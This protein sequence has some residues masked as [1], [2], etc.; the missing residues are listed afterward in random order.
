MPHTANAA[1]DSRATRKR[2]KIWGKSEIFSLTRQF[3][4]LL[5]AKNFSFHFSYP[6]L[7]QD[8]KKNVWRGTNLCVSRLKKFFDELFEIFQHFWWNFSNIFFLFS[9]VR[10]GRVPKREKAR[11]EA[12]MQQQTRNRAL[13]THVWTDGIED[14][15]HIIDTVVGAHMET[16]EFTRERVREMKLRAKDCPNYTEPTRVSFTF[17][18][19]LYV[20]KTRNCPSMNVISLFPSQISFTMIMIVTYCLS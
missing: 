2:R 4:L 6:K 17:K 16:C 7:Q 3:F 5:R 12:A 1:T 9:A 13:T 8:R 18:F 14:I 19:I 10:F 11:I 15:Q 20:K